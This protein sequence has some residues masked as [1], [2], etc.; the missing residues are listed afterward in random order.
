MAQQPHA[1]PGR[2]FLGDDGGGGVAAAVVHDEDF[3]IVGQPGQGLVGL[4]DGLADAG[5]LVVCGDHEG[6]PP[7]GGGAVVRPSMAGNP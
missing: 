2:R 5:L 7:A 4:D 1:R 3:V 6:Q